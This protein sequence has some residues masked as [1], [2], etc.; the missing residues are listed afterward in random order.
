MTV[1][2]LGNF[3]GI[4]GKSVV[5]LIHPVGNSTQNC[6]YLCFVLA[7][8]YRMTNLRE[9]RCKNYNYILLVCVSE[10]EK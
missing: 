5:P 3:C 4:L 6:A 7:V 2:N 9:I 8:S 10:A 1:E